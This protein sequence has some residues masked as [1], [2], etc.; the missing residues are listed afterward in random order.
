MSVVLVHLLSVMVHE[1]VQLKQE[2]ERY[3]IFLI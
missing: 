3:E 2:K 1:G